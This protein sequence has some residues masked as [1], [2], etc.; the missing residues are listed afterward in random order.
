MRAHEKFGVQFYGQ[1]QHKYGGH[2]FITLRYS[3]QI[4][5]STS[6]ILFFVFRFKSNARNDIVIVT[7]KMESRTKV[8]KN[9]KSAINKTTLRLIGKPTNKSEGTLTLGAKAEKQ[10]PHDAKPFGNDTPF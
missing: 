3:T 7:I 8:R 6:Q 9:R 10:L 4:Y 2:G 5:S 1:A